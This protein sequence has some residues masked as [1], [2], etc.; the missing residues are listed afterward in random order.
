MQKISHED[1]ML[2]VV[3]AAEQIRG[4]SDAISKAEPSRLA[5]L[6]EL[7]RI[8]L[9][10]LDEFPILYFGEKALAVAEQLKSQK[11]TRKRHADVLIAAQVIAGNHILVTRNIKDFRDLVP[12]RQL[13]NWV[14]DDI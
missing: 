13:Q 2:P 10:L 9:A 3:V 5:Q 8:T 14:D 6:Q 11:K 1:V 4:R 12:A 7:F